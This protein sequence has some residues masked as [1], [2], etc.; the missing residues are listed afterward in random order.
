MQR[1]PACCNCVAWWASSHLWAR[2]ALRAGR[3]RLSL[4]QIGPW[5][6]VTDC[7]LLLQVIGPRSCDYT[8]WIYPCRTIPGSRADIP[9]CALVCATGSSLAPAST[10]W[11]R[12]CA[13]HPD[14]IELGLRLRDVPAHQSMLFYVLP[15][16]LLRGF[17]H[18]ARYDG[19]QVRILCAGLPDI[20]E[21]YRRKQRAFGRSEA[22]A[23]CWVL[24]SVGGLL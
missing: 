13:K 18:L 14:L 6:D 9:G 3:F 20:W 15:E 11:K 24:C 8:F 19:C 22:A 16:L 2:V 21:V 1:A 12:L 10:E 4:D 7:A 17:R 5:Q 23:S